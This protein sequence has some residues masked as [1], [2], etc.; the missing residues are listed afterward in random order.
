M[1]DLNR[2]FGFHTTYHAY[3]EDS[4]GWYFG[5][6]SLPDPANANTALIDLFKQKFGK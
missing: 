2:E 4:F 6:N 1:I 5:Y 3:H